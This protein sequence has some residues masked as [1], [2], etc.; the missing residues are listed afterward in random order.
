[1]TEGELRRALD[2]EMTVLVWTGKFK[3]EDGYGSEL[4]VVKTLSIIP[5]SPRKMAELL[6]DS[7]RVKTYNKMSLGRNDEVT[8]QNGIDTVSLSKDASPGF[9]LDG[10][11]KVRYSPNTET[12]FNYLVS[13]H[14]V[15][16]SFLL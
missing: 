3:E 16:T 15:S 7:D 4:P 10:E 13:A 1:M 5:M 6:M 2:D 8:F 12:F 14:N 9:I 11:A